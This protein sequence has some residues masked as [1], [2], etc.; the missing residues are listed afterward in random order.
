MIVVDNIIKVSSLFEASS[1][2]NPEIMRPA[3]KFSIMSARIPGKLNM[4]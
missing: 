4:R 2:I 3:E 1:A